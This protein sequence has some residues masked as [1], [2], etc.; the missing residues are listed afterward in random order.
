MLTD[1]TVPAVVKRQLA[2]AWRYRSVLDVPMLREGA[3]IGRDRR[4][5]AG[6]SSPFSDKEIALLKTF[7]DQAVIAIENVRL[8]NETKEALEQQTATAE[9]LRVISSSPTDLQ[10]VFDVDGRERRAILRAV[11]GNVVSLRW[12]PDP[13]GGPAWQRPRRPSKPLGVLS[14]LAEPGSVSGRAIL[15][16]A[17]VHSTRENPEYEHG[18]I[19]Q[20]GFRTLLVVPMLRDREPI[21][22]IVITSGG[23]SILL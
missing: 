23:R 9:I 19:V 5:R 12:A 17:V 15:T 1:P 10:P 22:A 2:R 4:S 21:G 3:S 14:P 11:R 13:P 16:R 6:S 20:A 8:F 18:A 7:A